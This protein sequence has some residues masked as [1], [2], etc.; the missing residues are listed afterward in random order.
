MIVVLQRLGY[1]L[2]TNV[3]SRRGFLV[4]SLQ[5]LPRL[6]MIGCFTLS[7]KIEDVETHQRRSHLVESVARGIMVI[8][9]FG[10]TIVLSVE[11]VSI[12]LGIAHM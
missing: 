11:R 12:I 5:S 4:N 6:V 10:W 7:N 9:L 2:K 1:I 3:G 8:S